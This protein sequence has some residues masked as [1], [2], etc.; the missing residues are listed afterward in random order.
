MPADNTVNTVTLRIIRIALISG[1]LLFVLV[2]YLVHR[3]REPTGDFAFMGPAVL[4]VS[5]LAI[6]GVVVLRR[7]QQRATTFQRKGELAIAGWALGEAAGITGTV[8]YLLSGEATWVATGLAVMLLAM[9]GL[10]VPE[11]EGAGRG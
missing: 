5:A 10:P 4:G 3:D 9:I 1:V 8:H 7:Q 2:S 11:A 6:V